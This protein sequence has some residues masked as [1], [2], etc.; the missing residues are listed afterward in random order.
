VV[1]RGGIYTSTNSGF[2]WIATDAPNT[3]WQSI[4]SSAD[5][6]KLVAV[7]YDGPIYTSIN[8]GATWAITAAPNTNWQAVA[9][10]A[11]GSKLV[12]ATGG[13]YDSDRGPIY[14]STNSG[15]TW[16]P[17]TVANEWWKSVTVSADGSKIASAATYF[18][19]I[20]TSTNSGTDWT[21][22]SA[23]S[24]YWWSISSSVDGIKL[25]AVVYENLIFTPPIEVSVTPG[26]IYVSSDSGITWAEATNALG[27][28]WSS[29]ASSADGTKLVAVAIGQ[30]VGGPIFTSID[31]GI[32]WVSNNVPNE[33]WQAVASSADGAKLVAVVNAGGIYTAYSIPSPQLSATPS[34]NNLALS[35]IIP[36]TNFVL[37]QN[38]DLTTPNWATLT[39]AP[40]L[41]LTNLQDQVFFSPSSSNGFYRLAT[42]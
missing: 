15:A 39:N 28:Y 42:Q 32:S 19:Q 1:N 26:S 10:S 3:N 31:S 29:I 41:N 30:N 17:T 33:N 24:G 13:I 16:T 2:T 38:C 36:S 12:A 14:T 6:S 9:S 11:D 25:A 18:N 4:A 5:G 20:Y 34:N 37:Q 40:T 8:S 27:E 7:I 35:W 21:Q 22:A 23:P